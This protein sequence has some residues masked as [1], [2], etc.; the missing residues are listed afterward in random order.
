MNNSDSKGERMMKELYLQRTN[1]L[2]NQLLLWASNYSD[3]GPPEYCFDVE[4]LA[5]LIGE[6]AEL[7][8]QVD[9]G[10]VPFWQQLERLL[11]KAIEEGDVL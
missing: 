3:L 11:S 9:E 1:G 6:M 2:F 10:F 8:A 5:I 4:K 7:A